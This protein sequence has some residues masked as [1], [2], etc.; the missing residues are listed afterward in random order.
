MEDWVEENKDL[1]LNSLYDEL[2]DFMDSK[3]D[4][5]LIL[6]L[7]IKSKGHSRLSEFNALAFEFMLVR[8]ELA[9]T[10]EAIENNNFLET[11]DGLGDLLWV[12]V[13]AMMELGIDPDKTIEAIYV[14]NMSKADTSEED[15]TITYNYYKDKNIITY[16]K[17]TNGLFITYNVSDHKVL[18]SY[19]FQKPNL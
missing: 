8:E 6:K 5:K 15:A 9:E 16:C 17:V 4:L 19:K 2:S 13:R 7:I 12:V 14:S 18:K 3:D 10:E 11:K 1:I